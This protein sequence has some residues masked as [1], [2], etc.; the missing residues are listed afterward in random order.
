MVI[1]IAG[2]LEDVWRQRLSSAGSVP[3]LRG[4]FMHYRVGVSRDVF[5]WVES[6][7]TGCANMG[8]YGIRHESLAQAS[9]YDVVRNWRELREVVHTL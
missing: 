7:K 9:D 6:Y 5:V 4:V 8:V 1:C 3:V 2:Q